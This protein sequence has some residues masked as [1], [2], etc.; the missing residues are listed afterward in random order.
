MS[1]AVY[2]DAPE[3][4]EIA[5]ELIPKYHTH[6]ET[7]KVKI[8]Y[9]FISKTPKTKGNE[10]WGS[11]K[12]VSGL[13]AYL[14]NEGADFFVMTISEPVWG[15]L[16]RDEQT[17][18][19]DHYLC[20]CFAEADQSEDDDKADPVKLSIQSPDFSEFNSIARRYGAWRVNAK[21]FVDALN[22]S[23]AT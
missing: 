23:K 6:L 18:L 11:V 9:S 7:F 8:E 4:K 15:A 22:E 17:A 2:K 16:S 12:K 13:N 19:V 10:V 20:Y 21:T 5:E 1:K 3:V 14:A